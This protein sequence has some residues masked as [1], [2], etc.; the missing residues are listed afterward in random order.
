[1]QYYSR[2]LIAFNTAVPF[3]AQTQAAN[4]PLLDSAIPIKRS[5]CLTELART[6]PTPVERRVPRPK[7][8]TLWVLLH[9]LKRLWRVVDNRRVDPAAVQLALILSP[10][11]GGA[12]RSRSVV[13]LSS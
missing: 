4:L 10:C 13:C 9:R 1:M 5:L 11:R 2:V 7:P 6:V 8:G 3:L 12:W